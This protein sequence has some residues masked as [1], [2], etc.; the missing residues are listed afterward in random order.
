[1]A[2]SLEVEIGRLGAGGDGVAEGPDGPIYVPFT[3]PGE[4][5]RVALEPGEDRAACSTCSSRAPTASPRSAPI[6]GCAAAAPSS[7]WK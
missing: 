5:V 3:L 4:R 7:T 6:S 1:M 2:L